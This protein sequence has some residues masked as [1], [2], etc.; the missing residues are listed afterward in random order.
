MLFKQVG[1]DRIQMTPEEEAETRAGWAV[2]NAQDVVDKEDASAAELGKWYE[3]RERNE[4]TRSQGPASMLAALDRLD[5]EIDVEI[6]R[7]LGVSG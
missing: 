5:N 3:R 7:L 4:R 1:P 2:A 6:A